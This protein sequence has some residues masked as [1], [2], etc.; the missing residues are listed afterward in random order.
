M[1]TS[2]TVLLVIRVSG[3]VHVPKAYFPFSGWRYPVSFVGQGEAPKT[4]VETRQ[5]DSEWID[6]VVNKRRV[7]NVIS[8]YLSHSVPALGVDL[9]CDPVGEAVKS[10]ATLSLGFLSSFTH[11]LSLG[12]E[13]VETKAHS[14]CVYD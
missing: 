5:E 11:F 14:N 1:R 12:G 7:A 4:T 10:G 9:R 2:S 6:R 8:R 3:L 13:S